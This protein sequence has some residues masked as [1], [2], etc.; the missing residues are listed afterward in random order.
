V[1]DVAM[2]EDD[3]VDATL[4]PPADSGKGLV[5]RFTTP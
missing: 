4:V 2:R 5:R 3:C 1:V